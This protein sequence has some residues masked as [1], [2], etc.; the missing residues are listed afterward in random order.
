VTQAA[1]VILL[2]VVFSK[3]WFIRSYVLTCDRSGSSIFL[4]KP[5]EDS[6]LIDNEDK[7]NERISIQAVAP[8]SKSTT[9]QKEI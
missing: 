5:K 3:T 7:T 4:V 9:R 8:S 1:E 2:L 6:L